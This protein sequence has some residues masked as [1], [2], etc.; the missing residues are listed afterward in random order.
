M[1]QWQSTFSAYCRSW[2]Q[3]LAVLEGSEQSTRDLENGSVVF[4]EPERELEGIC[5]N[6]IGDV[7]S[8]LQESKTVFCPGF[9]TFS[10][11]R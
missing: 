5:F 2:V 9:Q 11:F 10:R 8:L 3:S 1:V 7:T 6:K 4:P